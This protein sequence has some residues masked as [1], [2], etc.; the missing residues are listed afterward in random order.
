MRGNLNAI[1]GVCSKGFASK[2]DIYT[3]FSHL[4]ISNVAAYWTY[5]SSE[6]IKML[7]HPMWGL[8]PGLNSE[9][10]IEQGSLNK[11]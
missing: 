5:E 4:H 10:N 2:R 11:S 3:Q 6:E 9:I 8:R 7:T 1:A